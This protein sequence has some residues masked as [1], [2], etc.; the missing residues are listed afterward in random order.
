MKKPFQKIE[1]DKT[2]DALYVYVS[3]GK[4]DRT[5]AIDHRVMFDV[6]KKGKIIGIEILDASEKLELS[7]L[8][9]I[10]IENLPLERV[11]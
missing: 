7:N 10:T 3:Q 6:D 9:N 4:I 5:I 11:S 1:Y 8:V 2:I